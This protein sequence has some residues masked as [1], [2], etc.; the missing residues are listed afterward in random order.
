MDAKLREMRANKCPGNQMADELRVS[1][2]AMRKRLKDLGLLAGSNPVGRP[3]V[4]WT[5]PMDKTLIAMREAGN[6]YKQIGGVIGVAPQVVERRVI[7]LGLPTWGR[8]GG[9]RRRVQGGHVH[10]VRKRYRP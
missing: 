1:V 3:T 6:G 8:G 2:G 7:E 4:V 5:V 9:F 10:N